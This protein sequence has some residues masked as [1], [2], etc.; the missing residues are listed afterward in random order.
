[1]RDFLLIMGAVGVGFVGMM[2]MLLAPFTALHWLASWLEW[3]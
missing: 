1:M 2:I 3:I